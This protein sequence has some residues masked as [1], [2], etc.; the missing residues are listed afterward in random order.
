LLVL[1]LYTQRVKGYVGSYAATMGGLD[2]VAFTG[3]IGENFPE[4][5]D[6][7]CEGLEFLGI[8]SVRAQRVDD[9]IL[10]ATAPGS[11]VKVLVVP[12]NEEL[13][14]ASDTYTIVSGVSVD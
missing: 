1:Q 3:G 9:Q 2:C 14:I 10:E 12:T 8:Q 7:T 5:C 6:W 4:V 13:A 11:S